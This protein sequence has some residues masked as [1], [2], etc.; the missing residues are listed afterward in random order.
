MGSGRMSRRSKPVPQRA[1]RGVTPGAAVPSLEVAYEHHRGLLFWV[2]ARLRE[3]GYRVELADALDL[4]HEFLATQYEGVARN[5]R[6]ERAR[7]SAYL[8]GAFRNFVIT[9]VLRAE[10]HTDRIARMAETG[11]GPSGPEETEWKSDL[12]ALE[13]GLERIP[14]DDRRLLALRIGE[15]LSERAV[16][17]ELGVSRYGVRERVMRALAHLAAE[18]GEPGV[19]SPS[20]WPLVRMLTVEDRPIADAAE[21]LGITPAQANA[22]WRRTLARFGS[23]LAPARRAEGGKISMARK[24]LDEVAVLDLL[25]RCAHG[26]QDA[27]LRRELERHAAEIEA[28]LLTDPDDEIVSGFRDPSLLL[29]VLGRAAHERQ[30]EAD[31]KVLEDMFARAQRTDEHVRD[32]VNACL[33]PRLGPAGEREWIRKLDPLELYAAIDAVPTLLHRWIRFEK[34]KPLIFVLEPDGAIWFQGEIKIAPETTLKEVRTRSGADARLAASL[35]DWMCSVARQ[36]EKLFVGA[37]AEP[38]GDK[39]VTLFLTERPDVLDLM[40]YWGPAPSN[41]APGDARAGRYA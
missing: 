34:E 1:A 9:T 21:A 17:R 2:L 23:V 37:V 14:A 25:R 4:I 5:Y 8:A 6:P 38:R 33:L 18:V 13:S 20:D 30:S 3:R 12:E 16:A 32:A 41:P 28:Y 40:Q 19:A 27:A 36:F 29:D 7:F 24:K 22:A 15:G 35:L 26:K 39:N 10:Q 31:R 11:A